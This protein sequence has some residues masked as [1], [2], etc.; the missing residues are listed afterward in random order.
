MRAIGGREREGGEERWRS[1]LLIGRTRDDDD[2]HFASPCSDF[3]WWLRPMV[4]LSLSVC[5]DVIK[6][7]GRPLGQTCCLSAGERP[8]NNVVDYFV[9]GNRDLSTG[10]SSLKDS[11]RGLYLRVGIRACICGIAREQKILLQS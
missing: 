1:A 7:D 5:F 6:G 11:F 4:P 3:D 2:M 8:A 9:G 10:S